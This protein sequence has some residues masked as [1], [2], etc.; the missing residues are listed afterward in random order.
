M[1]PHF[2]I[3]I[4][5]ETQRTM[6]ALTALA[7]FAAALTINFAA[8]QNNII[9]SQEVASTSVSTGEHAGYEVREKHANGA[10]KMTGTYSNQQRTVANGTFSFYH[11]NGQLES[12]GLY[13][14]GTKKGVWKRFDTQGNQLAERVYGAANY[15]E[16]ALELGW[17]TL[18]TTK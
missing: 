12:T 16:V 3:V 1:A 4:N 2:C 10:L 17:A 18:A 13:V 8:A 11:T 7:T 9:A 15:Q 6:N 5:N 14:N